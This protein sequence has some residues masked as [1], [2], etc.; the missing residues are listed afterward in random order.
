[1]A[2]WTTLEAGLGITAASCATLR[3]LL[4]RFSK[5]FHQGFTPEPSNGSL[6]TVTPSSTEKSKDQAAN[7]PRVPPYTFQGQ[8]SNRDFLMSASTQASD[9]F[10]DTVQS[11]D[12]IDQH[13]TQNHFGVIDEESASGSHPFDPPPPNSNPESARR[14]SRAN[15]AT[16]WPLPRQSVLVEE[17]DDYATTS[18]SRP[19][20]P[21]Q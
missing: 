4:R 21:E 5:W 16:W 8:K 11:Q 15:R 12:S 2:I 3:P 17:N 10:L 9:F 18:G 14:I 1:L 6:S 7:P 20:K 13:F 19:S